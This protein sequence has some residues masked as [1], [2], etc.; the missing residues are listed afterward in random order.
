MFKATSKHLEEWANP[1]TVILLTALLI[2]ALWVV[3]ITSATNARL[4][5]IETTGE[6]LR[7]TTHAVEMQTHQQLQLVETLLTA[8]VHWLADHPTSDPR[9]DPGFRRLLGNLTA[10]THG[11]VQIRLLTDDGAVFDVLQQRASPTGETARQFLLELGKASELTIG[12]PLTFQES[13]LPGL[14]M[15]LPVNSGPP[16]LVGLLAVVD[17][18]ALNSLYEKQRLQSYGR[19]LLLTREGNVLLHAPHD[20]EFSSKRLDIERLLAL[21]MDQSSSGVVLLDQPLID[22]EEH[23]QAGELATY[24]VLIDH[25]L[26]VIVSQPV[27]EALAPWLRQTFW[28]VLLAIGITVPLAVVAYRSLRL[29]HAFT[30]QHAHLQQLANNDPLTGASNRPYFVDK[31]AEKIDAIGNGG[32]ALSV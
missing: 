9:F 31:L 28:I 16:H 20:N 11:L 6:T 2:S 7:R 3:V 25:P 19:I 26:I 24:A 30:V 1:R 10:T 27:D 22:T 23:A 14:P 12:I 32:S 4:Q 17:L 18:S 21:P 29:I 15:V 13:G 8:C 5:S